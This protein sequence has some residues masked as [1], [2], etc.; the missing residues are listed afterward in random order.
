[1]PRRQLNRP[2]TTCKILIVEASDDIRAGLPAQLEHLGHQIT[3]VNERTAAVERDDLGTFDLLVSDLVSPGN[4]DSET[5]TVRSFK[6]AV[7][8]PPA[9]RAFP[10][11]H[12]IIE[13]TLVFKVR[14]IDVAQHQ[15]HLREKIDLEL[16][17]DLTLMNS[18]VEYLLDRVAQL[19]L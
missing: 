6:L 11:L 12:E 7:T 17:S 3:L 9:R 8:G 16:P 5:E 14:C 1:M 18:V 15:A 10:A 4:R 2:A 19:G 13:K